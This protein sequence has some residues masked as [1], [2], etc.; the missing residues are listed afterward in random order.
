[1]G[2]K[3]RL[4]KQ[5]NEIDAIAARLKA[6]GAE[7]EEARVA[8]LN[9]RTQAEHRC[10]ELLYA[11][12]TAVQKGAPRAARIYVKKET[13]HPALTN[14]LVV[15]ISTLPPLIRRPF[16][17]VRITAWSDGHGGAVAN[18]RL[19]TPAADT[20]LAGELKKSLAA[21]RATR[22]LDP[23]DEVKLLAAECLNRHET[24]AYSAPQWYAAVGSFIGWP[25]A[26]L[27]WLAA[28]ASAGL[29][30]FFLGWL[31]A[32]VVWALARFLWLPALMGALY[33]L[34][35]EA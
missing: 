22:P 30:G 12:L 31:P 24:F 1:M 8:A 35:K 33:L 17:T 2:R 3:G 14:A 15:S 20:S 13:R 11:K 6:S 10:L 27:V 34:V 18:V 23:I 7:E 9:T 4:L 16:A 28:M 32:L 21:E 26:A 25:M 5:P 29:S 19:E